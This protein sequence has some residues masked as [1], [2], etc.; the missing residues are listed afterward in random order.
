MATTAI[1]PSAADITASAQNRGVK[2]LKS[3]DFFKLLITELQ[4]QDPL[5]PSKTE[6]MIGQVSQIRSIELQS[7]LSGSLDQLARAQRS[8]TGSALLGRFVSAEVTGADGSQSEVAGVVTGV[9]FDTDGTA[10][11][12]LDTGQTIRAVD[13]VRVTTPDQAGL[14]GDPG[15]PESA[16][17]LTAPGGSGTNQAPL[18]AP[19]KQSLLQNILTLGGLIG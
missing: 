2:S 10:L 8:T 6:D 11:L 7:Q 14:F 3:E 19:E 5:Q 17:A 15:K 18:K 4:Q 16:K 1:A 9:R 12:E 13:V